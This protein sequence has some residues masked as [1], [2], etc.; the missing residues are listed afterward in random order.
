M[1][2]DPAPR[3]NHPHGSGERLVAGARAGGARY[4]LRRLLG[5]G[6][7][8]AV[9]LAWDVKL[10][11]EVAL[12]IL[13]ESLLRDPEAI[14]RVRTET[15]R[16]LQLAHPH[17]ARTYDF[18]QDQ[19]FVAIALEYVDGWSL[20]TLRVDKPQARY[21]LEE[22][23]PWLR[24]LC[25]AL[26]YAHAEAG[27]LH[28]GLRPANLMVNAREQLK[29]T[30]F[31]IARSLQSLSTPADLNAAADRLGFLSPQQA[32]G[33][34]PSLPDDVYALGATI[35]DLLTGTP[36]FYQGEILPQIAEQTPPSM[37]ERLFKRGIKDSIPLVVEQT[38]ALCLAKDPAQR[39]QS[40]SQVLQLL[41]APD[42]AEPAEAVPGPAPGETPPSGAETSRAGEPD[43]SAPPP[44]PVQ[45]PAAAV[46]TDGVA[47]DE[48]ALSAAPPRLEKR[49]APEGRRKVNST[50][51]VLCALAV[52]GLGAWL[53]TARDWRQPAT[54]PVVGG[55]LDA[56]FKPAT[57]TDHEIRV[58][59]EQPDGKLVIG[60]MFTRY[61]DGPHRGIARLN[62][63]GSEDKI[64][65]ATTDGD[66][67]ALAL[68]PDGKI[69]LGGTLRTVNGRACRRIARLNPDGSLDETFTA[70]AG[71][72]GAVRSAIVQPDGKIVVA[73]NFSVAAGRKQPRIA[74][75]NAAGKRDGTF[76]PG[77]GASAIIWSLA[78]QPDGKILA[79]GDF[80]AFN[81]KPC[82]RLVRLNPDGSVDTIFNA[83]SGANA[84]VFT[85]AV[86]SDGRILI[87][88][89]FTLVNHVER[90]RIARL[91]ATG[92]IDETFNPATGPNTG[93]RCL[94]I[95]AD[96]GI[97]IGGIFTSFQGQTRNRIARLKDDGSLDAAFDP[98]E[99]AEE[100]V[101]WLVPQADGK[102]LVVG[103]FTKF[104]GA[105]RAR[106]VRVEGGRYTKDAAAR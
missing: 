71:V 22:I 11:R 77:T 88:G 20:A 56:G 38:V 2:K 96:G 100:V 86:Q 32:L 51:V 75:F 44:R 72:N 3:S 21:S 69:I 24:Q 13:P 78:L 10:E 66:V 19:Q 101:R 74:R 89:D 15:R 17:I 14:E 12:K 85:V 48:G 29:V 70:N 50:G 102:I 62:P 76:N 93:I 67:Y 81:Q 57:N 54:I 99:G 65:E 42:A 26:A 82:G 83:G 80:T 92:T 27:M 59:L 104:A 30:D 7:A 6:A 25:L 16:S 5:R 106:I 64:F 37:T 73:G 105:E 79:V 9:W 94:A 43:A 41:E 55:A 40:V 49:V 97:L 4:I 90:N 53:W 8:S 63:D 98:G 23:T 58:A 95:Q 47:V 1:A 46:Q 45:V 52:V 34:P 103:G 87:G 68:Q 35:Y 61:G 28:L 33:Q 91:N 84:S 36:P 39:P 31:G 60:G 18:V